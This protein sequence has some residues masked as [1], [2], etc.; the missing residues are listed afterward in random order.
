SRTRKPALLMYSSWRRSRTRRR[1]GVVREA[2]SRS[3]RTGAVVLSMR[4]LIS[5]MVTSPD[6]SSR[7]SIRVR[8]R[9]ASQPSLEHQPVV[10]SRSRV[11]DFTHEIPDEVH[12]K[13][14]HGA[15]PQ[16]STEIGR[17]EVR[18]IEG[19]AIIHHLHLDDLLVEAQTDADL[20]DLVV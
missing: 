6:V 5:M 4:P 9:S 11:R 18:G 2:V 16:G 7:R 14:P 15:F 1:W 13:T 10:V 17:C 8:L 19:P 3:P 20:V 12:P